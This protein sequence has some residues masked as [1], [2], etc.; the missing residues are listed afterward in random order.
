MVKISKTVERS[1]VESVFMKYIVTNYFLKAVYAARTVSGH[2]SHT[3]ISWL[4][5]S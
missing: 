1:V 4:M 3:P 2:D 5:P